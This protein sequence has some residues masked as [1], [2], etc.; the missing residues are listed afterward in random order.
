MT[1]NINIMKIYLM[2]RFLLIIA[3]TIT[4]PTISIIASTRSTTVIPID[5]VMSNGNGLA[6]HA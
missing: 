1:V 2:S 5:S 6:V 4:L 3:H